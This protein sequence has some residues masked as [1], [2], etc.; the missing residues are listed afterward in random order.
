[1]FDP[2]KTP[3]G[4]NLPPHLKA[5]NVNSTAEMDFSLKTGWFSL[6]FVYLFILGEG[7]EEGSSDGKSLAGGALGMGKHSEILE[8]ICFPGSFF[9]SASSM[10]TFALLHTSHAPGNPVSNQNGQ[11]PS[12]PPVSRRDPHAEP[13]RGRRRAAPAG[14]APGGAPGDG[15]AGAGQEAAGGPAPHP[16]AARR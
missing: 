15:G 2:S 1:M 16:P 9:L 12:P 13:R 8:I 6:P 4:R 14:A 5:R 3:L 10:A 7:G 11:S